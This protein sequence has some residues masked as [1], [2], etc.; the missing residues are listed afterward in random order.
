MIAVLGVVLQQ[1]DRS[2]AAAYHET[3]LA[4]G[5][6]IRST[7]FAECT[8]LSVELCP[9]PLDDPVISAIRRASWKDAGT[10]AAG[11]GG[12]AR[13]GF[14]DHA[15]NCGPC[16]GEFQHLCPSTRRA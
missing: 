15:Q 7:L 14:A 9:G 4:H 8:W 2:F 6:Q 3:G 12:A 11:L 1:L 13:N 16:D 10:G 5:S